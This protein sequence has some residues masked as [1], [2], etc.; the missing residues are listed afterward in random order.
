MGI[1]NW[2][3]SQVKKEGV[4]NKLINKEKTEEEKLIVDLNKARNN[5]FAAMDMIQDIYDLGLIPVGHPILGTF[6]GNLKFINFLEHAIKWLNEAKERM[7]LIITNLKQQEKL[8]NYRKNAKLGE[9]EMDLL[10]LLINE[11]GSKFGQ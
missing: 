10:N 2:F 5:L 1:F 6:N 8:T 4:V 11:A 9:T 3:S 7:L